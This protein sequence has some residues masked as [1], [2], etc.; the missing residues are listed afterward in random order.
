MTLA[1]IYYTDIKLLKADWKLLCI[2]A[3][4]YTFVNFLGNFETTQGLIYPLIDWKSYP[5]TFFWFF[6]FYT[7]TNVLYYLDCMWRDALWKRRSE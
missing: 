6:V 5:S 4:I 3:P 2:I 1:N 7:V